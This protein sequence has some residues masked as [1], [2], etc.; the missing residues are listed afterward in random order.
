MAKHKTTEGI[1]GGMEPCFPNPRF[2]RIADGLYICED[3]EILKR[4]PQFD[5][6]KQVFIP[7]HRLS[8]NLAACK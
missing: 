8:P 2:R 6:K 1:S 4:L 3:E 5:P 7:Y